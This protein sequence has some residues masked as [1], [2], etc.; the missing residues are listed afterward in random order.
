VDQEAMTTRGDTFVDTASLDLG[1]HTATGPNG[2]WNWINAEGSAGAV[3]INASNQVKVTAAGISVYLAATVG[4][5]DQYAQAQYFAASDSF[6]VII[7]ATDP[8]GNFTFYGA[9]FKLGNWELW[10][11]VSLTFTNL[12]TVA[13]SL[14]AGDTVKIQ[15]VGTSITVLQNGAVVIGPITD[16][17]I[18]SGVPGL[19]GRGDA[20]DPWISN[21]L[22]DAVSS[23]SPNTL[24]GA[25]CL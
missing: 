22:A 5:S 1:A 24:M 6:P 12:G 19:Q 23:G 11:A 2:G 20:F 14:T 21:F 8:G 13:G 18:A 25:A 9:R 10:K 17:S 3:A 7:R 16:A 4:T 15:A